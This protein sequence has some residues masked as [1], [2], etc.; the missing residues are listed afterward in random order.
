LLDP[1]GRQCKKHNGQWDQPF[2]TTI[3]PMNPHNC[4]VSTC[5]H[6]QFYQLEGRRGG[7]CQQLG[8]PVQSSWKSCSL[9]IPPFA[10]TW[11]LVGQSGLFTVLDLETS[12][13]K[14]IAAEETADANNVA[15]F[16]AVR[17]LSA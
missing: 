16:P 11:E 10:P 6:C 4:A 12:V 2:K 13:Q 8:V 5:R 15:A 1:C 14:A 9:A 7:Y 3:F 17:S